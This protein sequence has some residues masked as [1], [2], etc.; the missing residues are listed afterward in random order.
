MDLTYNKTFENLNVSDYFKDKNNLIEGNS[1][2]RGSK[3]NQLMS[4]DFKSHYE[5]GLKDV[6][7]KND[8][9]YRSVSMYLKSADLKESLASL[10]EKMQNSPHI[11][12]FVLQVCCQPKA[13][14]ITNLDEEFHVEFFKSDQFEINDI[15]LEEVYNYD[16]VKNISG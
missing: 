3:K 13:G 8:L 2:F 9:Q 6:Q 7:K 16:R 5:N 12:V 14:F 4:K 10:F 11:F 1:F 15:T